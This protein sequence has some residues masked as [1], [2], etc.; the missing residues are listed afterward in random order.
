MP[1]AAAR[2][3]RAGLAEFRFSQQDFEAIARMLRADAGISLLPGKSTLVYAPLSKRLRALGVA[4]FKEYAEHLASPEGAG[5]RTNMLTALTTNVTRFFREPHHFEH[6]HTAVL[7]QLLR[8]AAQHARRV[9][10]WSAACSTGEEAYSVAG[11]VADL[12]P[13]A[14]DLDVRILGTDID[15]VGLEH[16]RTG[17]YASLEGV[18]AAFRRWFERDGSGWAVASALRGLVSFKRLNLVR[19]W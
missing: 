16:A 15:P 10:L 17:R 1:D 9:R 4:S 3:A 13:E 11:I 2:L 12:M 5:E 14:A 8:D 7:P 6:L 19:P 18:P